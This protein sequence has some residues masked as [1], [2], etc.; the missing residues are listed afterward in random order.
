MIDQAVAQPGTVA[1]EPPSTVLNPQTV[2]TSSGGGTPSL[3]EGDSAGS[4]ESVLDAELA[5]LKAEDA[6]NEDKPEK[7]EPDPAKAKADDADKPVKEKVETEEK[8]T[9][10]RSDDGKFAKA[11]AAGAEAEADKGA[12]EEAAAGQDAS[13][14]ARQSEGRQHPEAPARFLPKEKEMWASVPN[15]VKAAVDRIS[16][17]YE[18]ENQQ[19]RQSHEEWTKLDKFQQMAKQH[20]VTIS[21]ALERYTRLDGLLMRDPIAGIREILATRG[22]TPEQYAQHVLN[23]PEAHRAPPPQAQPD[24]MVRQVTGEVETLRAEVAAMKME[25][26]ASTIIEPFRVAHPRFDELQDD[27]AFFLQSGKIPAS[28][29]PAD[30]LEAAYDM[31]ERINPRSMSA[32]QPDAAPSAAAKPDRP[33]TLDAG[34]KSVRGAPTDGLDTVIQEAE[35]D[36]KET[37]RKEYRR[38]SA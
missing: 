2:P 17:E 10:A 31:A 8:P 5:R 20:N 28:L 15:V 3:T 21:D 4:V 33:A 13:E 12:P 25:Q 29:T 14:R 32:L 18:A 37:L 6:K 35:T 24:P 9:K 30:R 16:R 1:L 23:N 7:T 19:F 26:A 38:M 36:L 11:A 27:I 34:Q 22:I